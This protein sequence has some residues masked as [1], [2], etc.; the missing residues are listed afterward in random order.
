MNT[1]PDHRMHHGV[2][3]NR[4]MKGGIH[5]DIS[6]GKSGPKGAAL[7][8]ARSVRPTGSKF[9]SDMSHS[10]KEHHVNAGTGSRLTRAMS[11]FKTRDW[12]KGARKEPSV[13]Q[14]RQYQKRTGRAYSE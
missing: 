3:M 8:G 5:H 7:K 9:F 14:Q 1:V 2:P 10:E 4:S 13:E 6:S 11:A 12:P